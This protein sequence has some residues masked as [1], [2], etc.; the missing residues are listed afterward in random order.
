MSFA[1]FFRDHHYC[2]L[3]CLFGA[4]LFSVLL[5]LF[6]IQNGELFLLWVCFVCIV[7]IYLLLSY[8]RLRKRTAYLRSVMDSLDRKYLLAELAHRPGSRLEQ[9]YFHLMKSA[10]KDMIDE[11]AE[12]RRQN[13]EYRDFVE[14]WIHEMKIPVTG[15]RLLCENN[16]SDVTR[17]IL[18]QTELI[19]RSVERVLYYARLGNV[20]KDYFITEF[21]LK[22]CV[23]KALAENKQLLIQNRVCVCTENLSDTVY[24]DEKWLQ[25]ILNQILINSVKYQSGRPL[26]IEAASE[27]FGNYVT[28]SV[29]DNGIG[30][31][32]SELG[33]VFDKG[34]VGTNGR[35]GQNA[36][37]I[38][39]YLC[40]QL[41]EKPGIGLEIKSQAG[42]Y[43]T[44]LLHFPTENVFPKENV[45]PLSYDSVRLN[46]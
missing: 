32:E 6:G 44:V 2:L 22:E 42:E 43:T 12:A 23:L 13:G 11:V 31:R 27:N 7:S 1:D 30:I 38:G 37:G 10:L 35:G 39:L 5:K 16:R 25:F 26:R 36:T 46:Q 3:S 24:C 29:T 20:E 41:C 17:R 34:F 28:L 4:L 19:S 21:S 18:T 40:R 15:I 8:M 14:Q 33:R 9:F 45:V